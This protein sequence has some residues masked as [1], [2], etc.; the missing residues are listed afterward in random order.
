MS[1]IA[2]VLVSV[3]IA[4]NG[5]G[6]QHTPSDFMS[7]VDY[8][9]TGASLAQIVRRS[10]T[11]VVARLLSASTTMIPHESSRFGEIVTTYIFEPSEVMKQSGPVTAPLLVAALGGSFTS[12]I[13]R[14]PEPALLQVG[15]RYALLLNG[16]DG[17]FPDPAG[18]FDIGDS[19]VQPVGN[20][21]E[22]RKHKGMS[23]QAFLAKLRKLA[24]QH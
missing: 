20:T 1:R 15:H 16:G 17:T 2:I 14:P 4:S 23:S 11:V 10:G 18:A 12:G 3:L 19:R 13:A 8:V 9:D 24:A 6:A 22:A 7:D 5:M 21:V